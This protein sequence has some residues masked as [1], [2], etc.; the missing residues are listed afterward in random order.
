MLR[1]SIVSVSITLLL[2]LAPACSD[3]APAPMLQAGP[4]DAGDGR[5]H[6]PPDGVHVGEAEACDTLLAAQESKVKALLCSITT[7]TCPALLRVEFKTMCLEYDSGSVQ[8]CVALYKE[9]TTCDG[10]EDAIKD[11]V[12]TAYPGTEPAGCPTP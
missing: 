9:Q 7:R 4:D 12:V 6:P 10:L 1:L 3:E 5:I 8:G 2:L 11:C